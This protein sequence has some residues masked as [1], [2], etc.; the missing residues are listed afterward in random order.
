MFFPWCQDCSKDAWLQAVGM[1]GAIIMPHNLYLHSALVKVPFP[2]CFCGQQIV[3]P[4]FH[5]K[6]KMCV[7]F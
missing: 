5:Y 1:V 2:L 4:P 7:Y 6:N 3:L